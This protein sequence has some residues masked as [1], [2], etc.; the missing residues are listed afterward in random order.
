MPVPL[1]RPVGPDGGSDTEPSS[2]K[3]ACSKKHFKKTCLICFI[4]LKHLWHSKDQHFFDFCLHLVLAQAKVC[5]K[6][7]MEKE[8]S[9][10]VKKARQQLNS[11]TELDAKLQAAIAKRKA[12][13]GKRL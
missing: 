3:E 4:Y 2:P 8:P 6:R 1:A 5:K 11:A 12:G 10:Q 13:M 9:E 7:R